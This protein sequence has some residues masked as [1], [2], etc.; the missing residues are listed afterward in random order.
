M[1]TSISKTWISF[2]VL[3]GL[4]RICLMF[5]TEGFYVLSISS[6]LI[7]TEILGASTTSLA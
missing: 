5:L 3:A 7:G 6:W 4:T 2:T 1:T